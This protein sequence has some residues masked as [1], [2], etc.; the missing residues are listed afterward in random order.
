MNEFI[1]G[2]AHEANKIKV[3]NSSEVVSNIDTRDIFFSRFIVSDRVGCLTASGAVTVKRGPFAK[4]M[5]DA[6]FDGIRTLVF[7]HSEFVRMTGLKV[8]SAERFSI[9]VS[10]YLSMKRMPKF[11]KVKG[12][13]SLNSGS[14]MLFKWVE[15]AI[16]FVT[17]DPHFSDVSFTYEDDI[18]ALSF[19]EDYLTSF[20]DLDVN[21][22]SN[23]PKGYE[24][25]NRVRDAFMVTY[26]NSVESSVSKFK[27]DGETYYGKFFHVVNGR[28]AKVGINIS[29]H[30]LRA[31]LN[32]FFLRGLMNQIAGGYHY[33]ADLHATMS[34]EVYLNSFNT[35]RCMCTCGKKE[36]FTHLED[37][38]DIVVL[39]KSKCFLDSEKHVHRSIPNCIGDHHLYVVYNRSPILVIKDIVL[40]KMITY[41]KYVS[42]FLN[43]NA[44]FAWIADRYVCSLGF[45][46]KSYFTKKT[47]GRMLG[48]DI[49]DA[50]EIMT[51]PGVKFWK[52]KELHEYVQVVW[53]KRIVQYLYRHPRAIVLGALKPTWVSNCVKIPRT[54]YKKNVLSRHAK[55]P[56]RIQSSFEG[57]MRQYDDFHIRIPKDQ[58]FSNF[59]SAI[60]E[61]ASRMK[62]NVPPNETSGI[63][64]SQDDYPYPLMMSKTSL[65][66]STSF[67]PHFVDAIDTSIVS[68]AFEETIKPDYQ[69]FSATINRLST[70][71]SGGADE[72]KESDP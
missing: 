54:L 65:L 3:R 59:E 8:R 52:D 1:G 31:S 60:K 30:F 47:K 2:N 4:Y 57:A 21:F 15:S 48:F 14:L 45:S 19:L 11:I 70:L 44:P 18:S 9:S 12:V 16:P 7:F 5:V 51:W 33:I 25:R 24:I 39:L 42:R 23:Y 20:R 66:S 13:S 49:V 58:W 37:V 55:E 62:Y 32:G 53:E 68:Q 41:H 6:K 71:T 35:Y 46:G 50:D 17:D 27:R 67:E 72:E 29:G 69:P 56:S 28:S 10:E 38:G 43:H 34:L 61:I 64:L 40:K 22:I 36:S 63:L 26:L